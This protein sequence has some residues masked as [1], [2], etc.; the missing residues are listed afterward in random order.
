MD[1]VVLPA[2]I[3]ARTQACRLAAVA[4]VGSWVLVAL[5][6]AVRSTGS[7]L[8]CPDWPFCYGK[9]VPLQADIPAGSGYTL[10]NV[11]L[12]HTHR[13]VASAVVVLVLAVALVAVVGRLERAVR[14]PALIAALAVGAQAAL[15]ALVVVRDLQT[16]LVTAHLAMAMVVIASLVVV[17][18]RGAPDAL[19][20]VVEVRVRE[21]AETVAAVALA[22][23]LAGARVTGLGA[24]AVFGT[25]PLLFDGSFVPAVD[26]QPEV[27]HLAHRILA[28]TLVVVVV[29]LALAA[30]TNALAGALVAL[31]ALQVALGAASVAFGS[32]TTVV[33]A[34]VT[35]ASLIWTAA[36]AMVVRDHGRPSSFWDRSH[37]P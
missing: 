8:A 24:G 35:V 10:W 11:W 34:H 23:V 31:V 3:D 29:R 37:G 25:N 12:E 7:G 28:A 6:A 36:V 2:T 22:T 26:S 20:A 4:L 13:L 27:F 5:G 1:A 32:P 18:A 19:G 30:R 15:G 9:V 33:V 16:E 14:V 17:V 21:R